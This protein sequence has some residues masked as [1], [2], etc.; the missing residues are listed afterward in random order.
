MEKQIDIRT[1]HHWRQVVYGYELTEVQK[2]D[3]DYINADDFD[4][5]SF[6]VYKGQVI[7][8]G[9]VFAI[10]HNMATSQPAFEAWHGYQSDSFFSG[11]VVKF[12]DD[13]EEYQIGTYIS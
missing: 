1:N 10:S 7:D 11:I 8:S 6:F 2:A 5:H 9:E 4:M 12:S 3:F 13:F